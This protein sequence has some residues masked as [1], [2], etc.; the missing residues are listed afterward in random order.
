MHV[1]EDYSLREM[2]TGDL[3]LVLKWR[4]SDHVRTKML[5]N[6]IVSLDEHYDWFLEMRKSSTCVYTIFER[7]GEPLGVFNL[8]DIDLK[9]NLCKWGAYLGEQGLPKGTGDALGYVALE[10]A[11]ECQ[12]IR[13]LFGEVLAFNK[14]TIA[15]H[16]RLGSIEEGRLKEHIQVDGRYEDIILYSWF[17][18]YWKDRKRI[19]Y[20]NVFVEVK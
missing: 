11:F 7:R 9:N 4:N 10:Y 20:H 17:D 14:R 6:H 5:T 2:D 8:T 19:L 3:D 13:K 18:Y 16:N 1:R 15:W 12:K